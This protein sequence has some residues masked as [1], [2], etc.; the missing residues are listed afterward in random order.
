MVRF[1][2]G[3]GLG[4]MMAVGAIGATRLLPTASATNPPPEDPPNVD[5]AFVYLATGLPVGIPPQA[6]RDLLTAVHP[7]RPGVSRVFRRT[8]EQ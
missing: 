4:V 1:L 8:T 2:L 7:R 3:W 5:D 6:A